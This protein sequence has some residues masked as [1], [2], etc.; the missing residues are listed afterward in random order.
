[1]MTIDE[2][3]AVLQAAR[4]GKDIQVRGNNGWSDIPVP[5]WNF[6]RYDYRIKPES[7]KLREWWIAG[8]FPP[9]HPSYIAYNNPDDAQSA[10]LG[11]PGTECV[12]VREVLPDE[13]KG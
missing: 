11:F 10:T 2:M 8:L 9:Q 7:R 6:G 3:V 5:A 12:H 1:M 4:E 13:E